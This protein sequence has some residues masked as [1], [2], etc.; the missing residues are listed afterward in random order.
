MSRDTNDE[1]FFETDQSMVHAL[2]AATY[3]AKIV[4]QK[5]MSVSAFEPQSMALLEKKISY[6]M[7]QAFSGHVWVAIEPAS[8]VGQLQSF[9]S[10]QRK[11]GADCLQSVSEKPLVICENRLYLARYWSCEARLATYLSHQRSDKK[12]APPQ[13]SRLSALLDEFLPADSQGFNSGQRQAVSESLDRQFSVI[14]GGPGTGKTTTVRALLNVY[15][16][17]FPQNK[18]ALLAPTGKAATRLGQADTHG[19]ATQSTVH[20]LLGKRPGAAI[21]ANPNQPLAYD[22]VIVDEA[23]ML[24]LVLADQLVQALKTDA[25]LVLLGDANQLDAVE[26]G[27]FFHELC[28]DRGV[29]QPWFSKLTHTYRFSASSL[30]AQAAAALEVGDGQ[31]LASCL[32]PEPLPSGKSGIERLVQGFD[33]YIKAVNDAG[34]ASSA[35]LDAAKLFTALNAY[36]VLV[37]VNEGPAGQRPLSQALDA[38]IAYRISAGMPAE[39]VELLQDDIADW[40]HGQ[41]IVF[42]KNDALL[43][44]SNGDTAILV[45]QLKASG[46]AARYEWLA[47]LADGRRINANLLA[48]YSL[49]WVLTVHKAQGSEFDDVAFV[50]PSRSVSKAL[51]YTALTRAKVKF[52]A[53][54]EK[55]YYAQSV[56]NI[57]PRRASILERLKAKQ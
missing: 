22:L 38:V 5:A 6:C 36:R 23:S 11:S 18:I 45:H 4:V 33:A 47:L 51:L 42:T 20:R 43:G 14:S 57:A 55:A 31:A 24:D 50:M 35:T 49:A 41:A 40:Y 15:S 25:K 7:L 30:V 16:A 54:G 27:V 19:I 34:A 3:F 13:L 17:L 9:P 53:F 56:S 10:V 26:T 8:M 12:T 2:A 32:S 28:D 44:V 21:N 39:S 52:T 37:A 48:H 46:E 1:G 29:I